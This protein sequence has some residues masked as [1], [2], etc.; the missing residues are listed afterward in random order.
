MGGEMLSV[1]GVGPCGRPL[2]EGEMF[3]MPSNGTYRTKVPYRERA[4]KLGRAAGRKNATAVHRWRVSVGCQTV[5]TDN[6]DGGPVSKNTGGDAGKGEQVG[7]KPGC[8]L[9]G[10]GGMPSCQET[11]KISVG[12]G[13]PQKREM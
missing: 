8:K 11:L 5:D 2:P 4:F 12:S 10:E 3:C 1:S 13:W 9:M 6:D 7:M